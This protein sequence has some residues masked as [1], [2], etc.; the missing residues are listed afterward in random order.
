MLKK[1][2]AG[3]SQISLV[4]EKGVNLT[5]AKDVIA[6]IT[7]VMENNKSIVALSAPEIGINKRAFCIRFDSAIKAFVN[8]FSSGRFFFTI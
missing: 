4:D 7:A 1:L 6:K 3:C 2:S 8:L 5:D